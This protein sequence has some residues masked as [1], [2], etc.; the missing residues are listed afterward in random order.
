MMVALICGLGD[1][2]A[3]EE[4]LRALIELVP[5]SWTDFRVI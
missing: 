4:A 5:K 2:D 1:G 3:M